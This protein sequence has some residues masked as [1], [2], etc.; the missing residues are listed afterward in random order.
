[1]KRLFFLAVVLGSPTLACAEDLEGRV[2]AN[3]CAGC[4]GTN[5]VPAV[6]YIPPLA[7]LAEDEFIKAMV[8]YRDGTRTATIMNRVAPAFTDKE[9]AAMA[10]YFASLP[11]AGT[12]GQVIRVRP[13]PTEG[14]T[15]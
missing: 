8:A 9:I 15:Q 6:S 14:A 13:E 5:G 1:M 2:M 7:G 12:D 4:H 11:P 3:T 10:A